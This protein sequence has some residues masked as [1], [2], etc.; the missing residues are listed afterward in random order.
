MNLSAGIL[1]EVALT[2]ST[3]ASRH[4]ARVSHSRPEGSRSLLKNMCQL[5]A[6]NQNSVVRN[7]TLIVDHTK[8]GWSVS[9]AVAPTGLAFLL[10]DPGIQYAGKDSRVVAFAY[11]P[12][13]AFF[14]GS[15]RMR[16]PVTAKM[17]LATAGAIG[18]VPGSPMPPHL[19]PPERAK[20]VSITGASAMRAIG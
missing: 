4:P 9:A 10:S 13:A 16:F 14:S 18:G 8:S 12:S 6:E 5:G 15:E 2:S 1:G 11:T 17:A 3:L 20:W 7:I 19:S